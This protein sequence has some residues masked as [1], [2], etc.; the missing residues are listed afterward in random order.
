MPGRLTLERIDDVI[1]RD[2]ERLAGHPRVAEEAEAAMRE[3]DER[4]RRGRHPRRP[5]A[6]TER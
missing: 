2:E 6:E 4:A 5:A 3:A 1:A